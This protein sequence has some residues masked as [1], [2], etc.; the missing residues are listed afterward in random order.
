[1]DEI[2]LEKSVPD[3]AAKVVQFFTSPAA[4]LEALE[5]KPEELAAEL[6]ALRER[7]KAD[8]AREEKILAYF[9]SQRERGLIPLGSYIVEV[10]E[11][12]GRSTT[13]WKAYVTATM[14]AQAV[15][16]AQ[17]DPVYTKVGEPVVSLSVKKLG[18]K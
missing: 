9:K 3:C 17:A 2:D 1:M 15:A 18:A 13:D 5:E 11:S 16:E 6:C 14:T 8:E 12:K 7:M 10:K 4:E